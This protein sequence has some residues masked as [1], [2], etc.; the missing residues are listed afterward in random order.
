[1]LPSAISRFSN[2]KEC[3]NRSK[4]GVLCGH[5]WIKALLYIY[6]NQE[7]YGRTVIF[8]LHFDETVNAQVKKQVAMLVPFWSEA[9]NEVRVKYQTSVM[10]WHAR[11]E[12][13]VK[14]MLG[15]LDKLAIPLR[16]ILSLGIDGPIVN[17]SIMH[18]INQVKKEKGYQPL[19]K[20]PLSWSIHICHNSFQKGM[21]QD[22]YNAEELCLNLYYFFKR[23][24]CR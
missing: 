21:T 18:K 3:G 4:Q 11:G 24:S 12:D 9:H 20:Y 19:V 22:G 16:L 7:P 6:D 14:E 2:C 17:K 23:S 10:F 1:M 15:V 5:L 8:I 13:V